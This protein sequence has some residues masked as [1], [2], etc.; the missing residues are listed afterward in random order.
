M[1]KPRDKVFPGRDALVA[2]IRAHPGE[3]GTREIAR[4][5]GLK[6]ADR[7]ELKRML[8]ELADQG[9]IEKRG[10]KIRPPAALPATVMADSG[11]FEQ[12]VL[13]LVINAR[14][15]MPAG[16]RLTV[17]V[18]EID[19]DDTAVLTFAEARPG[20]EAPRPSSRL[21][22]RCHALPPELKPG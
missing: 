14:D 20:R 19:L 12:V 13:N 6:N 5:F 22:L 10:K 8:R 3:I 18:D 7:A 11:Q 2:F 21:C 4:E 1:A 15:A 16:G 17:R 9:A